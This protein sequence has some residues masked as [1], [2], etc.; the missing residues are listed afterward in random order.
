M[1]GG[2]M[3]R[4]L[5]VLLGSLILFA[6]VLPSRGAAAPNAPRGAAPQVAARGAATGGEQRGTGLLPHFR[7]RGGTVIR[8][9]VGTFDPRSGRLPAPPGIDVVQ[10]GRLSA[11]VAQYWLAQVRDLQF[12]TAAA[13]V[14]AAGG[15]VAGVVSEST[16]MVRATPEQ[17]ARIAASPAI[18]WM[19]YYQPAW[20]VPVAAGGRKA[21]LDLKGAQVYRVSLFRDEPDLRSAAR[22]LRAIRGV[23][24]LEDA[25]AVIDVRATA[26][27]V[28]AIASIPAVEWVGIKPRGV[29]LNAN[30]RWV[31]DTGVRDVYAATAP[32]RLTGAGQTAAVAD[33]GVN[34]T[35]DLNHRA[36]VAFRDCDAAGVCKE[37]IYTQQQPGSAPAQMDAVVD[38][39]TGHRKMVAYFDIAGTGPNMYDTSS[40]GSHTGGS[41]D[42]DQPP[43]DTWTGDDGLA[44]AAE[45][46]HQNIGSSSG[47]LVLPADD[48]DLWRQAYRPRNPAGVSETSPA[49]GNPADY[50]TNYVSTEDART[51]NNSYGL[52]A[53][54]IDDGSAVRLDKFVWDHED[55]VIVV[56]A[57]NMGPDAG[58]IGSPSV[59]KNNL[60]SGASVNGRQPMASIDSMAIFSSHGPTG[61]GRLGPDV[62][63]PGQIVVSVKGG[64]T[65]DYHTAQGT[66]MSAPVLTGLSTLVRQYFFDGYGPAGGDG[67]AGGDPSAARR[68]NPSAALV[69]AALANGAVRMRGW[70]TGDD[71]TSRVQDGQWPSA[72][73][74]YGRV[75]LDNSLYFSGDPTNNWFHDVYRADAEAFPVSGAPATRTYEIDVAAG[76]PLDVTL[77]WTDAPNV[78]P[79]ASPALVNNLDLT[80]TGPDGTQYVGN[81]MNSRADPT[82]EVA[83]TLPGPAAPDARNLS[84][85][86]RVADPTPGTYTVAVRA[87]PIAM[88]NQGFA[89]AANGLISA[90][91]QSFTPGPPLQT[92]QPGSPVMSNVAITP[93]S[94]DSARVT[95]ETNEPTMAT[96]T[97]T[98][99]G[100]EVTFIDSYNLGAG[101]LPGAPAADTGYYGNDDG[102]VETSAE[103]GN[104]PV[105]GTGHEILLTGLNPGATYAVALAARD[106]GGGE[107]G[108]SVSHTSPSAVYQPRAGDTAQLTQAA[109]P[110]EPVPSGWRTGTQMYAGDSAGSGLLGAY[111]F[112][113]PEDAV[114]PSRIT[115]AAVEM[116]SSHNWV[117]YYTDDPLLVVDLLGESVEGSWGTQ[118][119]NTIHNAPAAARVYPETTHKVGAYQEYAFTFRCSELNAL[120]ESLS[121]VAGGERKAAFRYDVA[122]LGE[123]FDA[124]FAMDFGFNRRSRGADLRPRLVLFTDDQNPYDTACDPNTPAPGISDVGIH[125]G[126]EADSVTVSWRTDVPSDS[127]VLFR[128]QGTEPWTQVGTLARTRTIHHVQVFGLDSSKEYEFAVR[129]TACNGAATTDTNEGQGYDFFRE[130]GGGGGPTEDHFLHGLPNDEAVKQSRFIGERPPETNLFHNTTAPAL[131]DPPA[132][133]HTTG[134]ANQDFIGNPLTAFWTGPYSGTIRGDVQ[135]SW[136]WSASAAVPKEAVSVTLFADPDWESD[137]P[138]QPS[139]VI[140]RGTIIMSNLGP[141]PT[142]QRGTIGVDGE[143]QG[144]L[145]VQAAGGALTAED[146]VVHYNSTVTD[147]KFA[148]PLVPSPVTEQIPLTGPAPP[149]SAGATGL[150]PPPTR[151]G[152]A[153]DADIAAGTGACTIPITPTGADVSVTKTDNPDPVRR[154]QTLTYTIAVTNGGPQE[155]TDVTATDQLPRNTNFGSVSTTK[156]TCSAQKR[157]VSCALGA[158]ARGET[159][160]ITITVKPTKKGTI[161]NVVTV[162]SA[163]PPDPDTSNNT[164]SEDTVV[165][166]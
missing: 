22:T 121:T 18:R 128:E 147:S 91:G 61:D 119:Y 97:L 161:S 126:A 112:R 52:I 80:V 156:G 21:L 20:R 84:E 131:G 31:N 89:L 136:Y 28:A 59:A 118:D 75:S 94:S 153:S 96:A 98:D 88:G 149:P 32:G 66:S 164:E 117:P 101:P 60:S 151:E 81:N 26:A 5:G 57:G 83:E 58:S 24:V 69:R 163:S 29:L 120:K 109:T 90:P 105:V 64:S 127:F 92:N 132:E 122:N 102:P 53:P 6:S 37:A 13:A 10:E 124:L 115:G 55:M 12:P 43:Y 129:S 27:Q 68:H 93:I 63:T 145:L 87:A 67:F 8:L 23:K 134:A 14:K 113:I 135:F 166:P 150:N 144:E 146:L 130:G 142:L 143:V 25:G 139:R 4:R 138:V 152:P 141:A 155:A 125:D 33:T 70:Y 2:A 45:H 78:L 16:Y 82:V 103:Y 30:S 95:F 165:Q 110:V 54:V 17:K 106:L 36:H 162:Q 107:A 133:Q 137:N 15:K 74:G 77:A 38:N 49:T 148:V 104:K 40:H 44:P 159:V 1:K 7:S 157:V 65:T 108:Q 116:A 46:V 79:A 35:Y 47:G 48:Y 160:T 9:L 3:N 158:L 111:M 71:G 41:V 50:T 11:G 56:S 73:Q 42:G 51:H 123:I 100:N 72:G 19:G 154:G 99:D 114:D 39:D 140:G 62:A 34:Y 86:V 76:Q 85:R